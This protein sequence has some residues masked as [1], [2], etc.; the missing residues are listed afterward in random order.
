MNNKKD[1][2]FYIKQGR[3]YKA[4]GEFFPD[5]ALGDGI[6]Y[7][8][9]HSNGKAI[10]N[11]DYIQG[12]YKVG[13]SK[14]IDLPLLCGMQDLTDY[15]MRSYEFTELTNKGYSMYELVGKIIALIYKKQNEL[16]DNKK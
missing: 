13:D 16:K 9:H 11:L 12:I 7:V 8:R 1:T 14:Q 15:V 6:W 5:N 3:R 4:I 2:N 10:T